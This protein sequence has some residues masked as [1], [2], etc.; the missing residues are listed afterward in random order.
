MRAPIT[1]S[2]YETYDEKIRAQAEVLT[3]LL[4]A[5]L[6]TQDEADKA[7]AALRKLQAEVVGQITSARKD[8]SLIADETATK[9]AALLSEKFVQANKA[10]DQAARQYKSVARMLGLKTFAVLVVSL[11]AI[12]ATAWLLVG[13]LLPSQAELAFRRA[14]IAEMETKAAKL[15]RRGVNLEW[16]TCTVG[17]LKREKP[18]FRSDGETYEPADRSSSYAVPYSVR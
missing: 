12:G 10:A 16:S 4:S 8:L 13:P 1:A 18:C 9:A 17:I 6:N 3:S 15:E 11:V 7:V 14:Q 2:E 5:G